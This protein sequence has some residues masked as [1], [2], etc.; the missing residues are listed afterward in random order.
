MPK[1]AIGISGKMKV[2]DIV[3]EPIR[4]YKLT[5]SESETRTI[6]GD[7]LDRLVQLSLQIH[8]WKSLNPERNY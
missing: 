5:E 7:L 2:L 1:S 6:V 4:F 8:E 3:A